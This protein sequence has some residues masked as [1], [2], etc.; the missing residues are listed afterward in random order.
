MH[1]VSSLKVLKTVAF[2]LPLLA[3]GPTPTSTGGGRGGT[4]GAPPDAG[5]RG[6]APDAGGTGGAPDA[7]GTGGAPDAGD[8]SVP[9]PDAGGPIITEPDAGSAGTVV[10][11]PSDDSAFIFD[12]SKLRTYE[13]SIAEEDLAKI[14]ADPSAEEYVPATLKVEDEEHSVGVRYKGSLGAWL[15]PCTATRSLGGHEGLPKLGKCSVKISF[16]YTDDDARFHGVKKLNFH[17]MNHDPSYMRDRL[18]YAMF[19]EMGVAAPRAVHARL[20]INGK[21][22]GLFALVEEVDG[23]FARSRF[24]EGGKGNVYKEVWPVHASPTPYRDALE[25]NKGDD[26]PVHRMLSLKAAVERGGDAAMAW[27]DRDYLMRYIAVDRVIINDDGVFNWSC[28]SARPPDNGNFFWY[29][30]NK[31]DRFWLIPWDLDGSFYGSAYVHIEPKWNQRATCTC[32]RTASGRSAYPTMCDPLSRVF[33][34]F[35]AEYE[36]KVDEFLAGP[37]SP[38]AIEKKV[39]AYAEQIEGAVGE[40]AG[41]GFAQRPEQ[42]AAGVVSLLTTIDAA[43]E[44]RGYPY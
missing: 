31:A 35:E 42:W 11:Q 28:H 10:P 14:N 41:I 36:A 32:R 24:S 13:L 18:G 16:D 43:R 3:C 29:E 5:G 44:F 38:L 27:L 7:G 33:A 15:Y 37:F 40:A 25:A 12:E 21:L 2:V 20:L 23:R 26:T 22:E 34:S 8:A 19:R 39:V 9:E 6:G 4:A 1:A 17:H 30:A